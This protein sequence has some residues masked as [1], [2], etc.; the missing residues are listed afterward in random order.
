MLF[1]SD[2]LDGVA[3][4]HLDA[5]EHEHPELRRDRAPPEAVPE[6]LQGHVAPRDERLRARELLGE[7]RRGREGELEE[8]DLD[9]VATQLGR[10]DTPVA[11]QGQAIEGFLGESLSPGQISQRRSLL[12]LEGALR[13]S[14]TKA[15]DVMADMDR[16]QL[17]AAR[18][19]YDD[20]LNR[21]SAS[22][23]NAELLGN[24][25]GKA[26]D[27]TVSNARTALERQ[28]K[29]DFALIDSAAG[30]VPVFETPRAVGAIVVRTAVPN[31]RAN[32]PG[33][34]IISFS[35]P[36]AVSRR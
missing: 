22:P 28:A 24:Q 19:R 25:V 6:A 31:S 9:A 15:A 23:Q 34:A 5:V 27:D 14:P 29:N 1:R 12:T 17:A 26:F 30:R 10:A 8:I 13:R 16:R 32:L 4:V 35:S 7:A 3:N 11:R 36:A 21:V 18:S 20:L 33:T 2:Q